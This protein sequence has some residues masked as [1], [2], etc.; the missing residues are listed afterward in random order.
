VV[1]ERFRDLEGRDQVEP[2]RAERSAAD[3][4]P[5]RLTAHE[6]PGNND[7]SRE[8]SHD[9]LVSLTLVTRWVPPPHRF[10]FRRMRQTELCQALRWSVGVRPKKSETAALLIELP[11]PVMR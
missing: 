1:I 11:H 4:R 5:R 6:Q 7:R 9:P 10:R 8:A 2:R 3:L